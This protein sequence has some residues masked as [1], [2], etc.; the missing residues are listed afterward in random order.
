MIQMTRLLRLRIQGTQ[1]PEG[2]MHLIRELE[3]DK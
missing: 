2:L 1:R 3:L